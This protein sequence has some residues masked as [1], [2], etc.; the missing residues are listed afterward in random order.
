MHLGAGPLTGD[1]F[2]TLGKTAA[3]CPSNKNNV[4]VEFQA[5]VFLLITGLCSL[6]LNCSAS[7]AHGDSNDV[8]NGNHL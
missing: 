2:R 5:V 8:D 3:H 4:L 6:V 1:G 7:G